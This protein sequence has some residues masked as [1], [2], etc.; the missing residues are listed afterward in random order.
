MLSCLA[1]QAL[2]ALHSFDGQS[3]QQGIEVVEEIHYNEE[4]RRLAICAWHSTQGAWPRG[5]A[6]NENMLHNI[7][8]NSK[9]THFL[10]QYATSHPHLSISNCVD[11]D[12]I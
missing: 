3:R 11:I 10:R 12:T 6:S 8:M 1:S 5:K 4:S 2:V 9:R 7:M